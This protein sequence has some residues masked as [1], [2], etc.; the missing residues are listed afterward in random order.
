MNKDLLSK[1]MAWEGYLYLLPA[2][3]IMVIFI[4]YPFVQ[5]IILS[6]HQTNVKGLMIHFK[7]LGNY[8]DLFSN[9]VFYHSIMITVV[10]VVITVCVGVFIGLTTALLCQKDFPG[11]RV[12]S[13]IYAMPMAIASSGIALIFQI[14]LN[15]TNGIIN[16]LSGAHIGW[17]TT[18]TYALLCVS[19]ITGW[20]NSGVN[21]LYFCAGLASI[22]N[23]LYESASID[24]ADSI[25]K[26]LYITLPN[27]RPITFF[28]IVTNIIQAFQAFGQIKILTMG[29]PGEA[30]NVLVYDIYKNAFITFRYGY[31]SAES[32][33]LF[34]IVMILTFAIFRLRAKGG[35][36]HEKN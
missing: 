7:G 29:G 27:L 34:I 31:A 33:T 10:F 2:I 30:T 1:I 6:L 17:L 32:V 14:M 19:F 4:I 21:F 28:V 13:A 35:Q 12:F 24:G 36:Q 20:L 23:S 18:P 8:I 22:D 25:R 5:T 15:Q 11:I 3:L 9:P 16:M 26:F